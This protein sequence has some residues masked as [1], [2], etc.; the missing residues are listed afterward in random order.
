MIE[1]ESRQFDEEMKSSYQNMRTQ[2]NQVNPKLENYS[3]KGEFP[4]QQMSLD[5]LSAISSK[6]V[7]EIELSINENFEVSPPESKTRI[8]QVQ[9]E[10]EKE[11]ESL[12]KGTFDVL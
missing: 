3:F 1:Q 9:E 5:T 7:E 6:N 12:L 11:M 10:V 2:I 4:A 8:A